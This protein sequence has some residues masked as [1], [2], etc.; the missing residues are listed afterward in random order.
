MLQ[1]RAMY[2]QY[3]SGR[4]GSGSRLSGLVDHSINSILNKSYYTHG[5]IGATR[6]VLGGHMPTRTLECP[7]LKSDQIVIS[8]NTKSIGWVGM[9]SLMPTQFL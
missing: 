1:D 2:R 4:L 6:G 5:P 8:H 9:T 3:S 7:T